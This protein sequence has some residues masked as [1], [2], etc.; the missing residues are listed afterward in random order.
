MAGTPSTFVTIG[1]F[2][3]THTGTVTSSAQNYTPPGPYSEYV[4]LT[5]V[6]TCLRLK[7]V[8]DTQDG[9]ATVN[10]FPLLAGV[11]ARVQ[12]DPG[13]ELSWIGASGSDDG[14]ITITEVSLP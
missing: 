4:V 12:I 9:V 1:E 7:E 2:R 5:T 8:G 6:D 11:Y 13:Y 3:N 14:A 10:D